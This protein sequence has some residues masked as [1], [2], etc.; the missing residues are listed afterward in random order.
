MKKLY[1]LGGAFGA[2]LSVLILFECSGTAQKISRPADRIISVIDDRFT[3]ARPADRH[4]LA[5]QEYDNGPVS[6]DLRMERM[7]LVLQPD[8]EQRRALEDLLAEQQD[9]DSAEYHRWLT[10]E[11]FGARF[12]ISDND[13]VRV[14]T[15][16]EGH[17][18]EV[19]PGT[20]DRRSIVFSGTAAQVTSAFHTAID[21]YNVNGRRYYANAGAPS[22]PEAMAEVVEGVVSL[23]NFPLR[24]LHSAAVSIATPSP[25]YTSSSTTHYTSPGDFAT[26]YDVGPLYAGSINGT[27]QTIAVIGRCNINVSDVQS[28]R[29]QMGLPVNNPTVI[30]NGANPGI[31]SQDDEV[32]ADLDVEWSGAVAPNAAIKFVISPSTST[33]G[34]V[35]SA[36]YIVSNN[37]APVVTFSFGSCEEGNGASGNAFWN[38]L[39]Q[40]AAA[41]GMT[42]MVAAGDAGA[43]GCNS[44]SDSIVTYGQ[45]VNALCSPP[46]ST[47][48]GGT[49]FNDTSNP[50]FYWSASSSATWE[51]ALSYIPETAW[52][53][54]GTVAGGS[55]LWSGG[56]GPSMVYKKPSWQAAPGV[57]ADGWRDVPD[58]SLT[59]AS[60]DA[61]VICMNG[62]YY[63]VGGTSAAAPSFAGLMALTAQKT[64]SRLGN[65]NPS[66]YA[67]ATK[68]ANGGAAIFHDVTMGNN[69]VPGLTG[70]SAGVG[71][72][73]A[74]GLGSVDAAML[75]NNWGNGSV[76]T[77]SFQVS[78]A[79]SSLSFRQG[80]SATVSISVSPS[81]GF[82][83]SVALL[84]SGLPSG[85][86]AAFSPTSV[87]GGYGASTLTVSATAQAAAA[88]SSITINASGGG[89]TQSVALPIAITG[90]SYSI[91]PTSATPAATA[92]SYTAQVTTTTGCSWTAASN[93]SWIAV[94]SG[95][96]GSGNG[97]VGYSVAANTATSTRSGAI[98]IA[99]LS[100]GVTQAAAAPQYSLSSTSASV[101]A[102][103][104]TGS[105]SVTA[106][107]STAVWTAVSNA[108]WITITSG[109]SST[110]SKTVGYSVAANASA[111][112]AG[113][114]TIAG[115]TFTVNQAGGSCSYSFTPASASA[116]APAGSFMV[117][118]TTTPGCAWTGVSN[119]SW[120]TIA[121][122]AS[123]SGSGTLKY[124][125]TANT[126]ATSRSGAITIPGSGTAAGAVFNVTQA[127]VAPAFTLNPSSVS[128]AAAASSGA[129]TLT[130]SSSIAS[131]TASSNSSWITIV[132]GTTG[133]GGKVIT[134]SVAANT[135]T[136]ARTGTLT[137]AGLTF[138]I[139]QAGITCNYVLNPSSA[140]LAAGAG[141]YS[142]QMTVASG[143]GWTSVSSA[144]WISVT[145]GASGNGNGAITYTVAANTAAT[146]RN[147]AITSGGAVLSLLQAAAV[148][149]FTLSPASASYSSAATT[150]SVTVTS[151]STTA[152][153]T[154][155]SNASW[156]TITSGAS[157]TGSRSVGYAVAA[158]TTPNTRTG[159]LTI[160]GLI[161]EIMQG[162]GAS[163]NFS[164]NPGSASIVAAAETY[165]VQVTAGS[166]CSWA[167][168][169]NSSFLSILSGA[170]GSGSGTVAWAAT[171]NTGVARSG[172]LTIA[173]V[174]F[175]VIQ[176]A[177]AGS[178]AFSL[179]PSSA[180]VPAS[181]STG[182]VALTST[183]STAAWTA[184]SN[185]PWIAITSGAS[186][187][188]N[189]TVTYSV[190]ANTGATSRTG[191]LTIAGL[192]YSVTQAGPAS[193]SCTY[194]VG[195][196][197]AMPQGAG[198]QIS[199]PVT[200]ASGCTWTASS[201]ASWL[202][203]ASGSPGSGSGTAVFSATAYTTPRS[204]TVTVAGFAV[205]IT[206]GQQ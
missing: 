112:R 182:S 40:Q 98:S 188:G 84:A 19:E 152:S 73:M 30:L 119:A 200:A 102:S 36:Q 29:A 166:G 39:W 38:S 145:A 22:I 10:P 1:P 116:A 14:V 157:S 131:W 20:P 204:A 118:V 193:A 23:H 46:Y 180:N 184:S 52:N 141:T 199:F 109:A 120:L 203:L 173:G 168:A 89:V 61:Y 149:P 127:G 156:I 106:A 108:S 60:H 117:Q 79:P 139:N 32:E 169:S 27:G 121:S 189:K 164:I 43:A 95:A 85:V 7:V 18:F 26:I 93:V 71:Y 70:Y 42:V 128:V 165:A 5:R 17:G 115:L 58:V 192:T 50:S 41:Q 68:Q 136:A 91:A 133:A 122:G 88:A 183:S 104:S 24:P 113:T 140:T 8:A 25:L 107:S 162:G 57:P 45:N 83:S 67:L 154:A 124:A 197:T 111:A 16:L 34:V 172:S 33:D 205:T 147:A 37:L 144:N 176:A 155:V 65:A 44:G 15:W 99:G 64:G 2:L 56:G 160:A 206:Q 126:A 146:A 31:I 4:P 59:A 3:V 96:S 55:E 134:Y 110:G 62:G 179:S 130:A 135:S 87:A 47:C 49:Q 185:A 167:A 94:T 202:T 158:N 69:S 78:A 138:T 194:A 129:V 48:V 196:A 77:P 86:T 92:G 81:G 63:V 175:P 75:V 151:S 12:G 28:F 105:V 174:V 187:P 21:A 201:N 6:P 150:G 97:T 137:I 74:T 191:T 54:S 35:L 125:V 132:N 100:L 66:F 11:A 143:C 101:G 161:F 9:P 103:A 72:D 53:E 181:A 142:A 80:T 90:C 82:T 159:T 178:S 13:M 114:L 76:A 198:F 186:G 195:I 123:G 177:A 148:P 190:A 170:S 171:P 153:W 51:S 163:C